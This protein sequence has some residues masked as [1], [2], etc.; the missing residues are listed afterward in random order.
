MGFLAE[1]LLHDFLDFRHTRHAANKND[2]VDL[3]SR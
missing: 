2:F 3:R 1:Y